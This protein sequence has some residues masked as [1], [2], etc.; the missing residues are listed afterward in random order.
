MRRR[1]DERL[2]TGRGRFTDDGELPGAL[3][4]VFVRAPHAHADIASI[5]IGPA[6]ALPGAHLVLTGDDLAA[7]GVKDLPVAPRLT[8]PR[9]GRR[10]RRPGRARARAGAPRRAGRCPVR[11]RQRARGRS[12]WPRRWRSIGARS[13]GRRHPRCAGGRRAAAFARRP[14]NVAFRWGIGDAAAVAAAFARAA[15]V[16]EVERA[17]QRVVVCPMEPRAAIARYDATESAWHLHTGNQGMVILRD[18]VAHVLG[19]DKH[20]VVVT[21]HDVG[22]AFGIRNGIYPNIR[23]SSSPPGSCVHR[24]AGGRR[25]AKPSSPMRRRATRACAA[26]WLS[27]PMAASW[28]SRRGPTRR[29]APR[30]ISPAISWPRRTSG[31]A[32]AGAVSAPSGRALERRTF[33]LTNTVPTAPYRGAGRPEAAYLTESLIEA[34]ARKLGIDAIELRR[35]NLLTPE[36]LP[37]DGRRDAL[38][39]R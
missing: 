22:G 19:V 13:G 2:V 11:G 32:S 15:H 35:R 37:P 25:A 21:S 31:A 7:L 33:V 30:C 39:Q 4:A 27:M 10:G 18:Q 38:R 6:L 3:W 9:D 24:C 20:S 28:R 8:M 12:T 36:S 26:G 1:E 17:S 23:R 29:S 5:D 16:V 34:A 14:G